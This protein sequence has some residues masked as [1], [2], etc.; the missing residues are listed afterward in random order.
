MNKAIS[1]STDLGS[2]QQWALMNPPWDTHCSFLIRA[3]VH[4]KDLFI[5]PIAG[6]SSSR[7]SRCISSNSITST[8]WHR[9]GQLLSSGVSFVLLPPSLL[10]FCGR[11]ARSWGLR[12]VLWVNRVILQIFCC[13]VL[14]LWHPEQ[15]TLGGDW[16]GGQAGGD[17]LLKDRARK[18]EHEA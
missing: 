17:N 12:C 14:N 11:G 6:Y 2:L 1:I 18:Q 15:V 16:G 13:P 3:Q 5:L 8:D 7:S 4:L 10:L 9:G